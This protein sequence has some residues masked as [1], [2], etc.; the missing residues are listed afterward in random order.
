LGAFTLIAST[1]GISGLGQDRAIL[2]PARSR[3][4][5][6][7]SDQ[8]ADAP[9]PRGQC[10]SWVESRPNRLHSCGQPSIRCAKPY[11][12]VFYPWPSR[13][14]CGGKAFRRFDL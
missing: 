4:Q 6:P 9:N 14:S 7:L 3:S 2:A 1:L 10:R 13:V 11:L 8:V 12:D 5:G